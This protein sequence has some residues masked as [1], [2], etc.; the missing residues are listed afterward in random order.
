MQ[1]PQPTSPRNVVRSACS[2]SERSSLGQ[3]R[4][5]TPNI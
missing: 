4:G 5:Q 1:P 2:S 3:L